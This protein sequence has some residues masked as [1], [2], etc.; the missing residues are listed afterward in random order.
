M[1]GGLSGLSG[2]V[3]AI[4]WALLPN[5]LLNKRAAIETALNASGDPSGVFQMLAGAGF[6]LDGSGGYLL[7][8]VWN[9]AK[10]PSAVSLTGTAF[11]QQAGN[12]LTTGAHYRIDSPTCNTIVVAYNRSGGNPATYSALLNARFGN[13]Q[14]VPNSTGAG[15]SEGVAF[16]G[17]GVFCDDAQQFWI[18]GVR[19]GFVPSYGGPIGVSVSP[20]VVA[21]VLNSSVPR[22]F[23]VGADSYDSNNRRA[24]M[25]AYSLLALSTSTP[26]Q[27]VSIS[28]FLNAYHSMGLSI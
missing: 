28:R 25:P 8:A 10:G 11:T 26:Q 3:T 19:S 7:G 14:S 16:S 23:C 18:D 6:W 17:N 22:F 24:N 5:V 9:S 20:H 1:G 15:F 27:I 2:L 12:V 13:A 21:S 4:D